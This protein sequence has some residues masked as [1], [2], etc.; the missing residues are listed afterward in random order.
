MLN[1]Y[2][3]NRG[4]TQTFIHH[5]NFPSQFNEINWNADYNGENA[6][7]SLNSNIDGISENYTLSLD[8]NDLDKILSYPSNSIPIEKRLI[9]DFSTKNSFVNKDKNYKIE[10]PNFERYNSIKTFLSSPLPNEELIIPI[11][12]KN[13]NKKSYKINKNNKNYK[14]YRVY[15]KLKSNRSNKSTLSKYKNNSSY[16]K[17]KY[18]QT[19]KSFSIPN[20]I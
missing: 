14:T 12:I 3:E 6:N 5:K 17:P 18:Y 9:N 20:S 1:S 19:K 16:I 4:I 8:N 7:I 10:I 13:K 2:I 15:K 11:T